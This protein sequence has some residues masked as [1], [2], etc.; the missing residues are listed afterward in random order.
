MRRPYIPPFFRLVP[1]MAALFPGSV[2]A[3][4][5]LGPLDIELLPNDQVQVSWPSTSIAGTISQ[6]IDLESWNNVLDRPFFV[7]DRFRQRVSLDS[8]PAGYFRLRP[9]A[10]YDFSVPSAPGT[11]LLALLDQERIR[12][13]RLVIPASYNPL[14][15]APAVFVFHGSGQSAA[16][17]LG[18]HPNLISKAGA[19]GVILVVPDG[20]PNPASGKLSWTTTP[21]V[22]RGHEDISFVL[23]LVAHLEGSLNLDPLRRYACGFSNGG[24]MTHQ[25]GTDADG[26]FAA[27]APVASSLG[28]ADEANTFV[29]LPNPP[30]GP[31]S[32]MIV[33]G[34]ADPTRP[35][36]GGINNMGT[37]MA[38]VSDSVDHWTDANGCTDPPTVQ[39]LAGGTVTKTTYGNCSDNTEVVLVDCQL[40]NHIWPDAADGVNFNANVEVIDFFLAHPRSAPPPA[41]GNTPVPTA[42]G[43]HDLVFLDQGEARVC[44]IQI[45]AGYDG[46]G[47][48]PLVFACPGRGETARSFSAKRAGLLEAC[49]DDG[50]LLVVAQ[51]AIDP[52]AGVPV[53]RHDPGAAIDDRTFMLNLLSH[54][55]A[56][57]NIDLDRVY[58]TG[59]GDGGSFLHFWAGTISGTLAAIAPVGASLGWNAGSNL[60]LP[61]PALEPVSVLLINGRKD[62]LRPFQGG[63]NADGFSIA[64]VQQAV[65]YWVTAN[66]C[67]GVPVVSV[68]G[69]GTVTTTTRTA[70]T[71][72]TTVVQVTLDLLDHAWPDGDDPV[73]YDG[74]TGIV[75]FFQLHSR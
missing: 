68:D 31:V 4:S 58:A 36:D 46:T 66:G 52:A 72:T 23:H 32:A 16:S 54:L 40:M 60:F 37:L 9:A 21:R 67:G 61:P 74:S 75:E 73:N 48:T 5:N 14:V 17:F 19:E 43:R 15:A 20:T 8:E 18:N 22:D 28:Y 11:H 39:V 45:P 33:N 1:V 34:R 63:K 6:T 70:C 59:F 51:G 29:T 30:F 10:P 64:S 13:Y 12:T 42:P 49:E 44:R 27:I 25:L 53:W 38:A 47:A 50:L 41:P 55:D 24:V 62:H 69:S 65:D 26:V 7:N 35:W 3:Q 2:H 57:W 71:G 56:A